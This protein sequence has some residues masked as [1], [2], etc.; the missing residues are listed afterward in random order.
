M[1]QGTKVKMKGGTMTGEVVRVIE[2]IVNWKPSTMVRVR[3]ENG[4]E[5]RER[6]EE[7]EEA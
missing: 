5:S 2:T 3:W 4:S 7:L 6:P 1:K